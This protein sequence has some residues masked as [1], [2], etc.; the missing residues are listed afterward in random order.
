MLMM[1]TGERM[2]CFAN[3][4]FM[5]MVSNYGV[6]GK[7]ETFEAMLFAPAFTCLPLAIRFESSSCFHYCRR[8]KLIF[9]FLPDEPNAP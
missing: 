5:T 2:V 9:M 4:D 7:E 1:M 3:E 8:K 6:W